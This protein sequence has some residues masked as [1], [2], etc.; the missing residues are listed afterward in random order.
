M[1]NPAALQGRNNEGGQGFVAPLQGAHRLA[2]ETPG[3]ALGWPVAARWAA[4][5][6]ERPAWSIHPV[7]FDFTT[8]G[9]PVISGNNGRDIFMTPEEQKLIDETTICLERLQNFDAKAL[10]RVDEL[11]SAINFTDA[12]EP[13]NR[14]IDLYR[15]LP[16]E[17]LTQLPKQFL[18][19]IREQA[20]AD[21][22][23]LTS[24]LRFEP[25]SP[26]PDRDTKL[27]SLK[28]AYDPAFVKLHPLISY[29]VRKST[30]FGSLERE[31]RS[32]V[33]SVSDRASELQEE[34]EKRK[35]EADA[36][37][38]A[39][40]KVAAEQGVSQ[41]AIYFRNAAESHDIG[42]QR[43]LKATVGLAVAL[44]IYAITTIFLHKIALLAP[45]NAYDTTQLAVSKILVFLTISFC[46]I[47]SSR[48]YLAHRHNAVVNRHRQNALATYEAIVKA[49]GQEGNRDVVLAKA[50]DCI[51]ST[52][53]T[54][55]G[56]TES[57]DGG[58]LSLVNVAPG[59]FKP[60]I[61]T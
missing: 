12:V 4:A 56:K 36:V 16:V 38:E 54:G 37:L 26:K 14:L 7:R 19:L 13:A 17:V 20:N 2:P 50:A 43:W 46:L 22:N 10:P 53:P 45:L 15:Q 5:R 6:A 27:N 8:T 23:I 24:I 42:S 51:F 57:T 47:L 60:T 58:N 49:V 28:S 35:K 41:Q 29:S 52:Q 30:D 44:G 33:Q 48:N 9:L 3:V 61:T 32:L 18:I 34:M 39:V 31:A 40:R 11:G 55:Y 25:G 21:H 1:N 59:G